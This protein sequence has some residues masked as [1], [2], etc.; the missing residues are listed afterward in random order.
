[1]IWIGR[2][3]PPHTRLQ[4]SFE[5]HLTCDAEFVRLVFAMEI[6]LQ[7]SI[8]RELKWLTLFL[9]PGCAPPRRPYRVQTH[10]NTDEDRHA[11]VRLVEFDLDTRA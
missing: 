8:E 3:P 7:G 10:L 9:T 11:K 4:T 6:D 1:M 2:T 5:P